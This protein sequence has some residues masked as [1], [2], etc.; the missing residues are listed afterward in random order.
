M[1]VRLEHGLGGWYLRIVSP[2][3]F[4]DCIAAHLLEANGD[5]RT[6]QELLSHKDTFWRR[7]SMPLADIRQVDAALPDWRPDVLDRANEGGHWSRRPLGAPPPHCQAPVPSGVTGK[8]S[9]GRFSPP[10]TWSYQDFV[11]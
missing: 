6:M 5:I 1:A 7:R 2:H 9:S 4:Q 3:I 10:A 8:G 11:A